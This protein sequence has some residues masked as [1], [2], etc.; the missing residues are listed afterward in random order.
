MEIYRSIPTISM[1]HLV[2]PEQ[3]PEFHIP[4]EWDCPEWTN[5]GTYLVD[6]LVELRLENKVALIFHETNTH[7]TF[8]QLKALTDRLAAG[9]QRLGMRVGDR[10]A[11]RGPNCPELLLLSIATWKAGGIVVPTPPQAHSKELAMFVNDVHAKFL[12]VYDCGDYIL[13]TEKA[14]AQLDT[15]QHFVAWPTADHSPFVSLNEFLEQGTDTFVPAQTHRDDLAIIYFT[16]GTTGVP[17]ACYHTIRRFIAQGESQRRLYD[18]TVHDVHCMAAPTGHAA[19]FLSRTSITLQHGATVVEI[20]KF[21]DPQVLVAALHEH[22]I[23]SFIAIAASWFGMLDVL[24]KHPGTY[25]L[26]ALRKGYAP[27]MGN[28]P[29]SFY[30]R[31]KDFGV[32]LRNPIGSTAFCGWFVGPA[33]GE[34]TPPGSL[35]K[36]GPGYT[37]RVVDLNDGPL[38]DVDVVEVGVLAVK[39]PTGLTY[40]NRYDIQTR[41]VREGWTVMDD[42]VRMDEQGYLWYL[43]RSDVLIN[44]AGYKVAPAE[45]EE[46]LRLHPSVREVCVVPSPDPERGEVVAAFVSLAE[47][48]IGHPTLE[49][50]LKEYVKHH[51]SPYKYPRMICF[52]DGLPRDPVGKVQVRELRNLAAAQ[53]QQRVLPSSPCNACSLGRLTFDYDKHILFYMRRGCEKGNFAR[54]QRR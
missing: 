13:E 17:K 49:Q 11:F 26:S 47:G 32:T 20:Q 53:A 37:V 23:T 50:E 51:I 42:L 40:W 39:G 7:Y 44:T 22:R 18:I 8:G 1:D 38:K 30:D 10:L 12:C 41:D 48:Y 6:R 27:Y 14:M 33:C 24:D 5:L 21:S 2:S 34:S 54:C 36:P 31:W 52:L 43:G 15:V 28:A 16:V 35:G 29:Q 46:V 25:D 9:L 19:G 45:V 4:T 3:Q